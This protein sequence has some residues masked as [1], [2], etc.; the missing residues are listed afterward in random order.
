MERLMAAE[1]ASLGKFFHRVVDFHQRWLRRALEK[2]L[3]LAGLSVLLIAAS[4][5]CHRFSGSD[6]M[7]EMD[8]GEFTLDY[9]TP[10]GASLAETNRVVL[11]MEQITK[12]IPEVEGASRR[13]GPDRMT[14]TSLEQP[15]RPA[16]TWRERLRNQ[17]NR[18]VNIAINASAAFAFPLPF[19]VICE[20]LGVDIRDR[21]R[22]GAGLIA[23]L[24]PT[25]TPEAWDRAKAGSDVVVEL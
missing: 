9:W 22:L 3:W 10:A 18:P 14:A 6:L 15:K 20:L 23:L 25:P 13:T 7:P 24:S 2:P 4:Y 21:D 16:F 5:L 11:R 19:T 1:E 8:E 17:M 12:A